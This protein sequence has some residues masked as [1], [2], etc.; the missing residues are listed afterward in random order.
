MSMG[1]IQPIA[2]LNKVLLEHDHIYLL[3]YFMADFVLQQER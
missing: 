2:C 1:Q 3:T